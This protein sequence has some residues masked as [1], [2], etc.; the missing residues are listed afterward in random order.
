M[1]YPIITI[2]REY[3]SAGKGVA[4]Q[5]AERLNIPY[6]DKEVISLTA[7][8][9][10][11]SESVVK[12]E[13]MS[14][15]SVLVNHLFSFTQMID[16]QVY[17]AQSEIITQLAEKPCVIVG[18]CADYVLQDK[19][20]FRVFI[21]C[22]MPRRIARVKEEYKREEKDI[23]GLI[24]KTDK[25]RKSYYEYYTDK[26][27]GDKDSYDMIIDSSIGLDLTADLIVLAA[28]RWTKKKQEK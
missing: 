25:E 4:R 26:K 22:D 27:W 12:N 19:D 8:K 18:R 16:V 17:M 24:Q 7:Q 23:A 1:A 2:S 11:F 5:V 9:T 20:I 13:Q 6:Y 28:S 15:A 21:T 10:G 3:G 14:K